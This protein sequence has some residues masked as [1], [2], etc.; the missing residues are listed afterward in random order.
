MKIYFI[1][2]KSRTA[3]AMYNN[4]RYHTVYNLL[5][6]NYENYRRTLAVSTVNS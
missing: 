1:A 6:L 5:P 2:Y 4:K 3:G